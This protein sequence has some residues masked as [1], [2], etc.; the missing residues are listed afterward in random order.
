MQEQELIKTLIVTIQ[1]NH[2]L[3]ARMRLLVE[4][5]DILNIRPFQQQP[6]PDL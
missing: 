2:W 6:T 4:A 1:Y 5:P 3:Q